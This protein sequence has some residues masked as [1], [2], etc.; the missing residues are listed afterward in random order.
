[1]R[2]KPLTVLIYLLL[3]VLVLATNLQ[4]PQQFFGFRMGADKHL[5]TW[6]QITTYLEYLG[7]HS[8]RIK[9]IELGKT[10]LGRPMLMT[11]FSDSANLAN[12]DTYRAIQQKLANPYDIDEQTAAQLT[13]D[14]KLVMMLSLNI[15]ST[16]IAS[17]Q[18]SVEL[19]FDLVTREDAQAVAVRRDVILLMIPS[20]NPDGQDMVSNWYLRHKNSASEGS[21][22]PRLYHHYAGHDNNRD[23]FLF[24]LKES[25]LVA[26]VLYQQWYPEIVYDQHQMGS[27]GPRMFL[28]PYKD[29]VNPNVS[30]LLLTEVNA[31]GKYMTSSLTG[32]GFTGIVNGMSFNSYFEGTMSKTP[33]WHNMIGILSEMASVRIASPLYFPRG[34]LGKYGAEIA[35]YSRRSEF[36]SPWSGGWWRLRDIIEY[37]KAATW[38]MLDYAVRFKTRIK[39]NFYD[40]NRQAIVSGKERPPYQV[41]V[42]LE[43]QDPNTAQLMLERLQ[44]AGVQIKHATADFTCQGKTYA[45]GTFL[46]P[47][48]QP[49]RAYIKDLF[50]RQKY[51]NLRQH[52]GG[53]PLRPYDFT[54]WT[55]PLQMGVNAFFSDEPLTVTTA[56]VDRFTF[57]EIP[58]IPSAAGYKMEARFSNAYKLANDLLKAGVSIWRDP[59]N[60]DFLIKKHKGLTEKLNALSTKYAVPVQAADQVN[61][62]NSQLQQPVRLA[63]YQPWRASID[64][65]WTRYVLDAYHFPYKILHNEDIRKGNLE[66]KYDVLILPSMSSDRLLEGKSKRPDEKKPKEPLIG[67][68]QMPKRFRGG[69]GK[70]GQQALKDFILKGGTLITFRESC[71]FAIDKLRVPAVNV[72]KKKSRS[73]Y[74]APGALLQMQLDK[75]HPLS[76]GM[77]EQAAVRF[78]TSPVFRLLTHNQESNAVGYFNED[79][80]LQSGWLIGAPLLAGRTALAEIKTARGKVLLFGFG[81]QS[82]A[83]TYGTFKLL[84]NAILNSGLQNLQSQNKG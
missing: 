79:N 33:L 50:E 40:L 23:W 45:A 51:P 30:S 68:P 83:Q 20:L 24:N 61:P 44:L 62:E 53:P 69:I 1:M 46:I 9:V 65:G 4:T 36:L 80:P 74:F 71:N 39:Q 12:L 29:P 49:E 15:H 73:D 75:S 34:S 22:M 26:P 31:L 14:G 48:A 28:P 52:E 42:P 16:E 57:S 82:R 32:Q 56:Q 18:E 38:A 41:V 54:G 10:T 58:E 17:S 25:Q 5:I 72:V 19:A 47:L 21:R 55:L 43:Q 66:G 35:R 67:A 76:W 84:F 8:S 63:I 81:V 77:P 3:P 60:G 6:N 64:E 78:T 27:S 13:R 11:V 59:A 37:E 70:D 2:A 7:Q